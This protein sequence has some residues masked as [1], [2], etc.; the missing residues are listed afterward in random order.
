MGYEVKPAIGPVNRR[1]I[2]YCTD[3]TLFTIRSLLVNKSLNHSP[4]ELILALN[5]IYVL[6]RDP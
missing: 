1:F 2:I 6:L 3:V 4:V 5:C